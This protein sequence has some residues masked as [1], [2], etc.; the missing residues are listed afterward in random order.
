MLGTSPQN[1]PPYWVSWAQQEE[2]QRQVQELVEKGWLDLVITLLFTSPIDAQERWFI[3]N[4][5]ELACTQ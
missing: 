4:V 3:P 5:C 2:I 1:K